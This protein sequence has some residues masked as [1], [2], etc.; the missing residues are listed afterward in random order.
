MHRPNAIA[1][2]TIENGIAIEVDAICD[3]ENILIPGIMQHV[4]RAG[5][6]SGDS[7]AVYP[8][9]DLSEKEKKNL[10]INKKFKKAQN[11]IFKKN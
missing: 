10:S 4:E 8:A 5:I 9:Y 11:E 3:E 6:H 2:K 7:T 1:I